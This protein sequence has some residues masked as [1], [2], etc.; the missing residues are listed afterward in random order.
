MSGIFGVID[1]THKINSQALIDKMGQTMCHRDWFTSRYFNSKSDNLALGHIG[2]GIFN[3]TP[4][5]VWNSE[6]TIALVLAGEFYNFP[7]HTK[8]AD[9][10]NSDEQLALRLY[11]QHG[12]NF[13]EHLNGVF[14]IGIWDK[15]KQRMV[16]VN[17]RFG[18]YPL[19][20][21]HYDHG[22]IFAPEMKGVL[23]HPTLPRKLDLTAL[24]QYMRFQ[25]LLGQR[26]F[27]EDVTLLPPA[28]VMTY[29][30]SDRSLQIHPYWTVDEIPHRPN[31]NFSEAI[32]E[33]EYL[34]RQAVERLSDDP[35]RV[36]V[37]LS[38]GLDSRAILN[39]IKQRPV[40][41]ITYGVHNCRDVYYAKQV[42]DALGSNHYWHDLP[43]GDW[44]KQHVDFHLTLTEGFHS[45]IH[46]HGIS[47]LP[48][49]REVMEVNLTGW[50]G[51]TVM[52]HADSIEPPQLNAVDDFSLTIRL[53]Y[54]FNQKYSWPSMTEGEEQFI[55][56]STIQND[57]KGLA[58]DSFRQELQPF[59]HLRPDVRG[60]YFYIHNHCLRSTHNLVTFT[61]SHVETRFPFF[62]YDLFE[63]LYGI[64]AYIRG[65]QMLYR[66]II[67]A[68]MPKVAYI[69][70][71]KD[72]L[73][74]IM[75]SKYRTAHKYAVKIKHHLTKYIPH[76]FVTYPTLYA[77]YENYLRTDL[78]DWAE[79]ILFTPK[80][81]DRVL[82]DAP[83]VR[84]LFQHHLANIE[85]W[86]IGK[87]AP[88]ITYEMMLRRFYD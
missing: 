73:L 87:I 20:Y 56:H 52:G 44:V 38:G 28:S 85:E 84:T 31:V 11:Q 60:E 78:R 23:A 79:T 65:H 16:I 4:Q 77:D 1:P 54:L 13:V 35:Y 15:A 33:G 3:Q 25:Q 51:G 64:P 34:F 46:A 32:E 12:E 22:L 14:I 62:D 71:E 75:P 66:A 69:P 2:I 24:T 9:D 68:H 81:Q 8:E 45:W 6:R 40:A 53:F 63:F 57:L 76:P 27:F 39:F 18:L 72:E 26:T 41:S 36:G 61:R 59:L 10:T 82:F 43:N 88:I 37:Y 29:C 58:F 86:T 80:F 50:D 49:A 67:E 74:P 70:Y 7:H 30:L 19:Y 42:A 47:T 55:Y 21:S 48:L 5:P 83:F 17:D